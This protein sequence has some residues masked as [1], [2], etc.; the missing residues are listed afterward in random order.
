M[1]LISSSVIHVPFL[2]LNSSS[3]YNLST[4]NFI[5]IIIRYYFRALNIKYIYIFNNE[6]KG[7]GSFINILRKKRSSR[8]R[9]SYKRKSTKRR[10][11]RRKE[12]KENKKQDDLYIPC[13]NVNDV[14]VP[15]YPK[16]GMKYS[17]TLMAGSTILHRKIQRRRRQP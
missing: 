6:K 7:S 17:Q 4:T 11:R 15:L 3:V 12:Q 9:K 14:G 13:D 5:I 1:N 8:K 2:F 16:S 10:I